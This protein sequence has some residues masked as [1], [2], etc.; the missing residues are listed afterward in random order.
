MYT[1]L[2]IY[3]DSFCRDLT[4]YVP[5]ILHVTSFFFKKLILVLML[6]LTVLD[7][8]VLRVI[9]TTFW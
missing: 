8:I 3:V 1:Y 4:L 9:K 6:A 7:G 2:Y 5:I